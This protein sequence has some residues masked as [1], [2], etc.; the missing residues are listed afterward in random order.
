MLLFKKIDLLDTALQY[1]KKLGIA[2]LA[3][4]L[5]TSCDNQRL[6]PLTEGATIL[7]FGDSLTFGIGADKSESY[8][9]ILEELTNFKVVNSGISGETT[10]EGLARFQTVINE[11]FPDLIILMEGGNDILRNQSLKKT[12][13][14]LSTMIE[15]AQANNIQV[16]LIGVPEKKL[17]SDSAPLYRALAEE[18]NVLLEEKI[19]SQLLKQPDLKSDP[20]HLN[21]AGYN[22]LAQR[23]QQLLKENGAFE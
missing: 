13:Q 21:A 8:P 17:F 9:S 19:L 6:I 4:L 22:Q 10:T 3:I 15:I 5:V 14:N 2:L 18:Y 16:I 12:H 23:I 20:V 11:H 1:F 7:A